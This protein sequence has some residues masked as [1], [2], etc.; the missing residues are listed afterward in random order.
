ME[1]KKFYQVKVRVT[2]QDENGKQ[3]KFAEYYLVEAVSVSDAEKITH[4]EFSN[5]S[6][7]FEVKSVNE[8]KI[9]DVLTA[10]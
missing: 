1:S 5:T 9:V 7:E 10:N 8:T 6:V 2:T 3:K 4:D